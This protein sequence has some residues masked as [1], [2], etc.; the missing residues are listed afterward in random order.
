MKGHVPCIPHLAFSELRRTGLRRVTTSSAPYGHGLSVRYRPMATYDCPLPQLQTP[1][2]L[3]P[4]TAARAIDRW[5]PPSN[6]GF[7]TLKRVE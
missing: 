6:S 4:G 3:E 5:I 2:V 7:R 1:G